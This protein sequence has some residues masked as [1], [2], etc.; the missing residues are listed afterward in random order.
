MVTNVPDFC[1]EE[2][3]EQVIMFVLAFARR[4]PRLVRAAHEHRWLALSELPTPRR[5]AGRRL[6]IL[7]F[8]HSGQQTAA[9]ARALG[10]EVLVWTRTPRPELFARLEARPA[11]FEEVLG[12]DYVSLQLPL[13]AATRGLIGREALRHMKPEGVLINVARGAIVDTEALVEAL[14]EGRLAGAALDVVDPAPLPPTH[15]LWELPNVLITAHTAGFSVEAFRQ[16]L[17]TAIDD[18]IVVARGIP[19]RNP[20]P[21]LR[22]AAHGSREL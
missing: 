12:C 10:L 15:P 18:T 21:E 6:G 5:A 2:M 19:P 13:T 22:A 8:G 11:S 16:S 1:S 4:L 17:F 3:A 14:R 9:K 20:V 7:G